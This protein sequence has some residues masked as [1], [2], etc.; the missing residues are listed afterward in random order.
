[1]FLIIS[2][3][4]LVVIS[5]VYYIFSNTLM[6]ISRRLGIIVFLVIGI[7]IFVYLTYVTKSTVNETVVPGA[8]VIQSEPIDA[9]IPT[10]VK[11]IPLD[12]NLKVSPL[13]YTFNCWTFINNWNIN[14]KKEKTILDTP[15]LKIMLGEVTPS[16]SV[17][18]NGDISK[19]GNIPLQKWC[20]ICVVV[21][22][23]ELD[24][25]INGKLRTSTILNKVP[26]ILESNNKSNGYGGMISQVLVYPRPLIPN[27]IYTIYKSGYSG[28]SFSSKINN[29][30]ITINNTNT[31]YSEKTNAYQKC[32]IN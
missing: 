12:P 7:I 19:A 16:I 28:N 32:N 22:S 3:V 25:Y 2:V 14:Y 15:T 17:I 30:T 5:I 1:M 4:I 10:V 23:N 21:R 13:N 20:N 9:L 27:D 29:S 31:D 11:E 24:I 18:T 8:T 26:M 6:D